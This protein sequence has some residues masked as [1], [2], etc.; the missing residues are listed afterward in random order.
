MDRMNETDRPIGPTAVRVIL[1]EVLV[2]LA[3]W[4][5]GRWFSL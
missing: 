4:S 5:L 3:L 2:L 1:V